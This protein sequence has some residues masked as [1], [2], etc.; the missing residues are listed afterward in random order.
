MPEIRITRSFLT[1]NDKHLDRN[2]TFKVIRSA[3]SLITSASIC[4]KRNYFLANRIEVQIGDKIYIS[5]QN[6]NEDKVLI[7][8]GIV[9]NVSASSSDIHIITEYRAVENIVFNETYKDTS[10]EKVLKEISSDIEYEASDFE[11][12]QTICRGKLEETLKRLLGDKYYYLNLENKLKVLD[13][14]KKGKN[15]LIDDC[16]YFVKSGCIA[17]FP[18][19]QL[20]INDI[21]EY[22]G[23]KYIVNNIVYYY[24]SKAQMILGVDG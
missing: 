9:Q 18:I 5:L 15:Y 22:Q 1:I 17:I 6:N 20:E 24:L 13:S 12:E 4:I 10:L 11:R 3:N 21:V 7:F 23:Q 16:L 14:P 19:P 8:N 2:F